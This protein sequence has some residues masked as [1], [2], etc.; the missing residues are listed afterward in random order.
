MK[1]WIKMYRAMLKWE[2]FKEPSVV[3]V[4][5]ALLLSAERDGR[6][7]VNL[8]GLMSLTGLSHNTV[9]GAIAKLVK[10][11]EITREKQGH[12]IYT[13]ITN[14]SEYQD[15]SLTQ[16]LGERDNSLTQNLGEQEDVIHPKNGTGIHPKNG[17]III[18]KNGST[19]YNKNNNKNNKKDISTTRARMREEVMNDMMVETGCRSV[20]ITPEQYITIAEEIFSDWEFQDLADSECNKAHFLAVLRIKANVK[21]NGNNQQAGNASDARVKLMQ[22]GIKAMAALAAEIGK[23][24]VVP[25]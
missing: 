21:R 13:T 17:S 4:F 3:T 11:G 18:P 16:N 22:D 23:P 5:L 12:K 20:G 8:G 10:S 2:H 1:G 14:W 9:T 24:K 25:F 15:K 19:I 6:A 7:D